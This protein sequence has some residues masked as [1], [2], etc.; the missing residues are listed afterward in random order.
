LTGFDGLDF[1]ITRVKISLGIYDNINGRDQNGETLLLVAI[2]AN[3][4]DWVR[5]LLER[6]ANP[7]IRNEDGFTPFH[8]AVINHTDPEILNLLLESG[9]V[10]I[11]ETAPIVRFRNYCNYDHNKCGHGMTALHMAV[12]ESNTVAADF[13]LTRGADPNVTT[14]NGFTPLH[15]AAVYAKGSMTVQLL[16]NHKDV[17]VNYLN[18]EGYSALDY[19]EYNEHGFGERIANLLKEKGAVGRENRLPKGNI[20]TK[21]PEISLEKLVNYT[22]SNAADEIESVLSDAT[23]P[24][25]DKIARINE[26]HLISVIIDSDVETLRLLLKNGADINSARGKYGMNALHVASLKGKTTDLIDVILETEKFDINGVDSGGDT[27]LHYA[28]MLGSN[29]ARNAPHLIRLGA[30]PNVSNKTR[31]TPL[32]LA[33]KNEETA[34]LIDIILETGQCNINTAEVAY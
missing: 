13:L 7:T 17:D 19:A 9:K 15:V 26:E 27:P 5:N 10:D 31:V 29:S 8:V 32:H 28:I 30:D 21:N 18:N 23:V 33:A 16:V 3:N 14:K 25:E 11:N 6:G 20:E 1:L 4:V 34:E 2:R 22:S 24:I 12:K